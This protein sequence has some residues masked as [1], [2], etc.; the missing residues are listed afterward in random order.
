[1]RVICLL[2]MTALR[3]LIQG[4]G[5]STSSRKESFMFARSEKGGKWEF[6]VCSLK[7]R[8]ICLLVSKYKKKGSLRLLDRMGAIC[9]PIRARAICLLI[10]IDSIV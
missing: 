7:V 2:R 10:S 5:S 8:A 1:M 3:F 6:C 4:N 9:R